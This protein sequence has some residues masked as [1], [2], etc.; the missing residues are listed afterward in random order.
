MFTFNKRTNVL[1][2][3]PDHLVLICRKD[4]KGRRPH[5]L[6]SYNLIGSS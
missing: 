3:F 6:H 4:D 2:N 5:M 1:N